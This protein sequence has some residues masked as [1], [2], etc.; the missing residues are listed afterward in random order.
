MV[1]GALAALADHATHWT[2]VS[3]ISVYTEHG[4]SAVTEADEVLPPTDRAEVGRDLYGAAKVACEQL[5]AEHVGDRLLV[6]RAG[7]IGGPGD[8]TDRTGY[9]VARAA[10][11]PAARMLVPNAPD[12]PTQV[13]DV[14]DLAG[15]LIA[16]A[17]GTTV[18]T[19]DA[20]GPVVPLPDW[21]ELAR[22]IGAHTGGTATAD[23]RWLL[24]HGVGQWTGPES[25]P[26][27]IAD[28]GDRY[29]SGAAAAAAGLRH[30]PRVELMTD[31]LGWERSQ[32]LGRPRKAGLTAR[33]E[34]ELLASLIS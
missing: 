11:D 22:R 15:W 5:S 6:A 7:L 26:L 16:A 1:R 29:W 3:S 34:Q 27:W 13:V 20:V 12:Q 8:H 28:A 31:L 2:Y 33:R 32:G 19:F 30:R 9:W 18:G 21:I 14:R 4:G 25:L 23:P 17:A 10:R 24:D